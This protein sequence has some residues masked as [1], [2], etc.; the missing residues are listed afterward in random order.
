MLLINSQCQA[1]GI[2]QISDALKGPIDLVDRIR[3]ILPGLRTPNLGGNSGAAE[4]AVRWCTESGKVATN[5]SIYGTI[6]AGAVLLLVAEAFMLMMITASIQRIRMIRYHI[7]PTDGE[8]QQG[9][10]TTNTYRA[11]GSYG[12]SKDRQPEA[13]QHVP[14]VPV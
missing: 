5:Q 12:H 13:H 9:K 10:V 2:D 14:G 1:Y 4:D 11:G 8:G 7:V 6:M 3:E